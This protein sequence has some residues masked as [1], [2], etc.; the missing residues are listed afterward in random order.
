MVQQIK[1]KAA[2]FLFL[3]NAKRTR[4]GNLILGALTQIGENCAGS[5]QLRLEIMTAI[6]AFAGQDVN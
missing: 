3:I 5:L 6:P 4:F 2:E 1:T